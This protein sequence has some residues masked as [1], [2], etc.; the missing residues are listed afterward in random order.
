MG[1]RQ[2][3]Y[4][5]LWRLLDRENPSDCIIALKASA[6]WPPRGYPTAISRTSIATRPPIIDYLPSHTISSH[7]YT[8]NDMLTRLNDDILLEL[9]EMLRPNQGLRPLSCT[10]R[11]LRNATMPILFSE[12]RQ[13]LA[14]SPRSSRT[15]PILPSTLWPHSVIVSSH[16][17]FFR[18]LHITCYCPPLSERIP[19]TEDP[20]VCEA[21]SGVFFERVLHELPRLTTLILWSFDIKKHG[22]SWN[23]LKTILSIPQLRHLHFHEFYLS[24]VDVDHDEFSALVVA[25]LTTFRYD[26]HSYFQLWNFPSEISTLDHLLNRLHHCLEHLE[27]PVQSAPI[28]AM[29]KLDWPCLRTFTLRGEYPVSLTTPIVSLLSPM[30]FLRSLSLEVS[31]QQGIKNHTIW[32]EGF[33][34]TLPWPELECLRVSRPES[35]D[36]IYTNLPFSLSSLALRSWPHQCIQAQMQAVSRYLG[37]Q[38]RCPLSSASNLFDV[39]RSCDTPYLNTLEVEYKEDMKEGSLLRL[40]AVKFPRLTTLEI[41]RYRTERSDNISL[42]SRSVCIV[43]PGDLLTSVSINPVRSRAGFSTPRVSQHPE[44]ASRLSQHAPTHV[45]KTIWRSYCGQTTCSQPSGHLF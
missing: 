33:D 44:A 16:I 38:I 7:M 24:P 11:W 36:K 28:S 39:I 12:C 8:H 41:H 25:P 40:I 26:L 21:F 42:V 35:S 31:H 37:D 43:H 45:R 30:S 17:S 9:F 1:R 2:Q 34:A 18:T 32:P 27:L 4:D 23:T 15:R 13:K 5:R 6:A 10:C 19:D 22:I 29:S 3:A 20:L 14:V